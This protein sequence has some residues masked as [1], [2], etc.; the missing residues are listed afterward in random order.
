MSGNET[1]LLFLAPGRAGPSVRFRV[2]QWRPPLAA[3][4]L[5][6]DVGDLDV[7]IAK[8]LVLLRSASRYRRV[9]VHRAFLSPPEVALL[10]R[11]SGGFVFDFDDALMFRDSSRRRQPSW[12]RRAR[13]G[14]ML[15]SADRV[16]AGNRY[17]AD[18][19]ASRA[20]ARVT[21]L[22][23]VVDLER[24]PD[25]PPPAGDPV[26]GWIGTRPNLPYLEALL[27]ALAPLRER[28]RLRVVCD[29]PPAGGDPPVEFRPW[30]LARETDEL[31]EL[32]VGLMPLPDDPWTRGK[33][34]LKILQCFAAHV[35]VVCSPVGTNREVVRDGEN[36]FF[37]TTNEQ[38]LER[39]TC[40][41]D[42]EPLRRRMG[43]AARETV[44]RGYSVATRLD[45]FVEALGI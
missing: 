37:A 38:W 18:W 1:R 39:I 34:A 23:T 30:S 9:V 40:L 28:A 42:D 12:Q 6:S 13:L 32:R 41:L 26:V 31:R 29:A 33:C 25:D 15:R 27:P 43:S 17:L 5:P 22:P 7:P 44:E 19:A 14:R 16:I 21:V 4:G 10:R 2:E 20:G 24:F 36:G 3:H 45:A 8:R 35:P 11:A